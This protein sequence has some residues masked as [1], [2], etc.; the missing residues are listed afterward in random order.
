M[1]HNNQTLK[2]GLS[3]CHLLSYLASTI[4]I[5]AIELSGSNDLILCHQQH[6]VSLAELGPGFQPP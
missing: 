6:E 3:K 4:S 1:K 2:L 5:F